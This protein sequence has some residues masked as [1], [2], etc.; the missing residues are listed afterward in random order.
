MNADCS[1]KEPSVH[2]YHMHVHTLACIQD[3]YYLVLPFI[4][5]FVM[6]TWG[7]QRETTLNASR[8]CSGGVKD[9]IS[10]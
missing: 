1:L 6:R 9:E 5:A 10:Q 4:T 3:F 2:P 7:K 8:V